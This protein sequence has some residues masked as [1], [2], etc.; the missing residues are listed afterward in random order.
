M[1]YY[2]ISGPKSLGL[3]WVV[4]NFH[5]TI[6]NYDNTIND[7]LRTLVEHAVIQISKILD[8][9]GNG[10]VLLSGGGVK[11]TFFINTLTFQS[12][13][14]FV[15]PSKSIIDYKEALI[16][17]FLGVLK[18]RNEINCMKSVTGASKNHST[19][20]VYEIFK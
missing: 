10:Q 1:N 15:I 13:S 2:Q 11:N 5:E 16:F 12:N 18:L 7:L 20:K 14:K 4:E 3:E 8:Q 9:Y 19:G 6:K 17:G